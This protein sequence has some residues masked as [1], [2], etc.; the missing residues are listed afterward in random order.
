MFFKQATFIK[1]SI[2]T[3]GQKFLGGYYLQGRVP[4]RTTRQNMYKRELKFI[5]FL[6]A[7]ERGGPTEQ[8]LIRQDKAVFL[9]QGIRCATKN[10]LQ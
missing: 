1:M 3:K 4:N 9:V 7:Q 10:V 5:A 2:L 8:G 6:N